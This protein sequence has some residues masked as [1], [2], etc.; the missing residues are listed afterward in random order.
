M[1]Q[2]QQPDGNWKC[3]LCEKSYP[4]KY[5]LKRHMENIHQENPEATCPLCHKIFKNPH[6]LETHIS[7]MHRNAE[8]FV[9]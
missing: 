1:I 7:K 8:A 3:M 4:R 9:L 6:A 5:A 2:C